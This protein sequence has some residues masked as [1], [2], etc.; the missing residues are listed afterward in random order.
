ML[1]SLQED[2]WTEFLTFIKPR[3]SSVEF[4]NWFAPI[5]CLSADEEK[6]RLEV[7]NIFVQ[8]YRIEIECGRYRR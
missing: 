6:V 5:Q 4:E 3:C 2:V 1:A 8:E 7:P